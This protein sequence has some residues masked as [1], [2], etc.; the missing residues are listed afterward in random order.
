MGKNINK[1]IELSFT[2]FGRKKASVQL[3]IAD[4]S[5]SVVRSVAY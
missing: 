5:Y 1:P 2:R 4:V 3:E